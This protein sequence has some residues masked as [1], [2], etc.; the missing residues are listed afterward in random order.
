MPTTGQ[1]IKVGDIWTNILSSVTGESV[2]YE[3]VTSYWDGTAM[4]DT[5]VDGVIYRKKGTEYLKLIDDKVKAVYFALTEG[6][7]NT[8]KFVD[9]LRSG[10]FIELPEYTTPVLSS[11]LLVL[12]SKNIKGNNSRILIS[13]PDKKLFSFNSPTQ[14]LK[15]IVIQGLTISQP[16]GT[17]GGGTNNDNFPI[18]L[19]GTVGAKLLFNNIIDADLGLSSTF[20][21]IDLVGENRRGEFNVFAFNYLENIRKMALQIIGCSY[22]INVGN[23]IDGKG[24]DSHGIRH[25]GYGADHLTATNCYS[26]G[27]VSVGNIVR[28]MYSGVT[29]QNTAKFNVVSGLPTKNISETVVQVTYPSNDDNNAEFNIVNGCTFDQTKYGISVETGAHNSYELS[30]SGATGLY[31]IQELATTKST[32]LGFN[33]YKVKAKELVN[34]AILRYPHNN[35]DFDFENTQDAGCILSQNAAYTSGRIHLKNIIGVGLNVY[36]DHNKIDAFIQ[37]CTGNALSVSGSYNHISITT[38]GNVYI[39]GNNNVIDLN[40]EGNVTLLGSGN[41]LRGRVGG[42]ITRTAGTN[43]HDVTGVIGYSARTSLSYTTDANG[44]ITIPHRCK[45]SNLIIS[46]FCTNFHATIKMTNIN[47]TDFTLELHDVTG[48]AIA[49]TS[50]GIHWTATAGY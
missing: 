37:D 8:Q 4:D 27:S 31:L 12:D 7:D 50:V 29:F 18:D 10:S 45:V 16:A 13:D 17:P 20:G 15:D 38:N 36:S 22:N 1:A 47:A 25:S 34:G 24:G 30:G 39:G 11:E 41:I 28:G 42:T 49:N 23:A 21:H 43:T 2:N 3:V 9:M 5:K 35:I 19:M 46:A 26:R 6:S 48:A 40:I 14:R 44:R 32:R 33:H